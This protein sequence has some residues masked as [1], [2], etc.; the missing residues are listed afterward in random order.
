VPPK[1]SRLYLRFFLA[2]TSLI[3]TTTTTDHGVSEG[4]GRKFK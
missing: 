4:K 1:F 3:V 2:C